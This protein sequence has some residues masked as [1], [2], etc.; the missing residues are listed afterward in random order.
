MLLLIGATNIANLSLAR[1]TARRREF[2]VRAA[3]GA[4]RGRL[5]RQLL[6][7]S[8][9][10]AG[11]GGAGG[12]ALSYWIVKLLVRVAPADIPRIEEVSVDLT[13]LL[14]SLI[15]TLLAAA[16]CGL[17]PAL[18]A[19][20]INLNQMLCEGG[21]QTAGGRSGKRTR[22]ALVIAEVAVTVILV[23]GATL[24]LRSFV[25]LSRLDPGFDPANTL[26][27]HLRLQGAKYRTPGASREFYRRL[28]ERLEARP[29]IEAASAVLIR[30]M[31]GEAGWDIPFRLAGQSDAEAKKNRVPNFEAVTPH[32]FRTIR[33]PLKAGRE[34]T[35][36]DTETSQPVAIISETMAKT[37]F[38][39]G[40]DPI[41]KQLQLDLRDSPWRT[42]VGVVGDTR[43]R[44]LQDVR[45]D[46]Y[47]PFAQWPPGFVNHFAV[48][49]K[50]E[51]KSM[52]PV[53]RREVS[54]LD[55]TQALTRVATME[56]LRAGHLAQPRFSAVLLNWLSGLALLLSAVGI[57]G[58]LA[59]SVAERTGEFGIRRALGAQSKDILRLVIGQGLRLVAIGLLAGF[60][61]SLALTR[62]LEKLLFGVSTTD[63]LTF[64][65]AALLLTA[66][67]LPACWIPARRAVSVDPLAALRY[68]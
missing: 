8:L 63:P 23:V 54:A 20:R 7:E 17:F 45:F 60:V 22:N 46:L 9:L 44:A 10:L 65:M 58:M 18:A 25:N 43:Y 56:E 3:L 38:G 55:P 6:T 67:A 62:L 16:V 11:A 59:V 39:A 48:R 47:I 26:T 61:A 35:D 15:A 28:I 64:M 21:P 37:I 24:I 53:V 5:A 66:A 1:A 19:S 36:F 27:M 52:L 33:L 57:Y 2:A 51:A 40:V 68:E 29:D 13:V 41:G 4:G 49:T 31:E 12:V 14:F 30:P 50:P 42:I 34:F 32:Y